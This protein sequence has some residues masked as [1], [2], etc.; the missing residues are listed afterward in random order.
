MTKAEFL[1]RFFYTLNERNIDYFV[2]GSYQYLPVDTGGSDIDMIVAERDM[3]G[4]RDV[5]RNI[6]SGKGIYLVSCYANANA[7]FYRLLS[8]QWGVQIDVFYKGLC[9]K[10]VEYYP[11]SNL[12]H[13]VIDYK[14]VKV[15]DE[16]VGYYVDYFKEIVHIGVAKEKYRK[17][18]L[19]LV[20]ADREKYKKEIRMLYGEEAEALVFSNLCVDGLNEIGK[21]LQVLMRKYILSGHSWQVFV[22]NMKLLLRLFHK[23]P[24]YV[25]VVEGTDGSGK[26]TIINAI[27]PILNECFHNS[28]IYNHLRP[29]VIPDLGVLLGKKEK[30]EADVVNT[31][32]HALKPSGFW[33][34]LVRWGYYM[35]DYTLGYMKKVWPA[36][37]TKSKVFIFD[38]YYYDYYIDQKRS[39]TTLPKSIIR[40]GECFLPKPDLILCLGGD[41]QKI[42][43]RKPETSLEEVTRQTEALS[44][45]CRKRKN[46]VWVDTTQTIDK[47]ID[48]AMAAIVD[49][50]SK[51]FKNVVIK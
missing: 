2:Y 18:F 21:K 31:D 36:I 33:G 17:A 10:G 12:K 14:G 39:R 29:N 40:M 25:I 1:T 27:T 19:T 30:Q 23:S 5:L 15:L 6:I 46:A 8:K 35:I 50:M 7:N 4:V 51:R 49:M 20:D 3:D 16:R 47:S 38:R 41:P 34:S 44:E 22:A 42:Y 45:F 26:S 28:V 37:H 24:G 43:A 11:L 48:T 13:Y 32:P 9:F